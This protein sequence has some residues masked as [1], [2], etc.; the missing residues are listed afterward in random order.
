MT[1]IF[2]SGPVLIRV[3]GDIRLTG[4][5][6][7]FLQYFTDPRA[8]LTN[9]LPPSYPH[10]RRFPSIVSKKKLFLA[11]EL[12]VDIPYGWEDDVPRPFEAEKLGP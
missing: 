10:I 1:I 9:I 2:V 3:S 4:R 5:L 8:K 12:L 7:F 11:L 6:V